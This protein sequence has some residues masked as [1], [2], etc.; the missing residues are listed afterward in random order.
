MAHHQSYW[1]KQNF[2]T[3]DVIIVG[4]GI[5]GLNAA[6]TIK[7]GSPNTS[8]IVLERGFLPNGASTKNAG[9][10]CFGSISELIEQEKICGTD[11]LHELISK[12]WSGLLKLRAL[13]GDEKICYENYGGYELFRPAENSLAEECVL[14]LS[15]FNALIADIVSEKEVY[16]V[17]NDQIPSFGFKNI[18]TL[19]KNKLEAQINPGKMMKNLLAKVNGLGVLV[20]NSCEVNKINEE[21]TQIVLE[22]SQGN[23]KCKK[24]VLTTNA[25]INQFYPMLNVVPGRGQVIITKPIPNLRLK[26]TFHYDKGFYYFRNVDDRILLGG[27]RNLDFK[28]EETT[29]FGETDKVQAA[30][31]KLLQTIIL[32]DTPFELEQTWSGIMAFGDKLHPIIEEINPNIFC[33][34]RCNG[35]G[36]AIGSN[37]GQEVG[38]LVLKDL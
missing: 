30:L 8:V 2:F 22:T 28:S 27:G 4:S 32:P 5:V 37:T 6:L 38:E 3:A 34:V 26:G 14:K 12:R 16:S 33:A 13:L 7:Q 36:I 17:A 23:F 15:H 21:E 1:E 18:S 20:L 9:F 35:M 25:F 11:G 29:A 24:V 19:L 10:A 31:L